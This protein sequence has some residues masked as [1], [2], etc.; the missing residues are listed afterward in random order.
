M[1]KRRTQT[2]RNRWHDAVVFWL[3]MA[4]DYMLF[5]AKN[6]LV[7][8]KGRE[9]MQKRDRKNRIQTGNAK[10]AKYI[11]VNSMRNTIKALNLTVN[12]YEAQNCKDITHLFFITLT[13]TK[14][15]KRKSSP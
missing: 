15:K 14:I 12:A 3:H 8:Q 5:T 13:H 1:L 10:H 7:T 6:A 2:Y 11:G 9:R 4:S